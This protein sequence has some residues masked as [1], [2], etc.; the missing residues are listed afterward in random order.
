LIRAFGLAGLVCVG[1]IALV[2]CVTLWIS[3]R[4]FS[5]FIH[6]VLDLGL[7]ACAVLFG[8]IVVVYPLAA[9]EAAAGAGGLECASTQRAY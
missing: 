3:G 8:A 7:F 4:P 9:A 2:I 5:P 1:V 6:M